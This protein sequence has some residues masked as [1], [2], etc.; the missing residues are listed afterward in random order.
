MDMAGGGMCSRLMNMLGFK[1]Y[2]EMTQNRSMVADEAHFEYRFN[3]SVGLLTGYF[4]P[5]FPV[6]TTEQDY[7]QL[8]QE[9]A[10]RIA[11][12][13]HS[14]LAGVGGTLY[15]HTRFHGALI[16][17]SEDFYRGNKS[18]SWFPLVDLKHFDLA[19]GS[20]FKY[21][22]ET[23]LKTKDTRFE[24]VVANLEFYKSLTE[25]ACRSLQFNQN[26]FLKMQQIKYEA[27][28]PEFSQSG[29]LSV[30][31]HARRGDKVS[32]GETRLFQGDE[33]VQKLTDVVSAAE[34]VIKHCFITS[35]DFRAVKEIEV[36]LR[37]RNITCSIHTLTKS[38][39]HGT[40]P[41]AKKFGHE[42]VIR[43]LTQMSI[44]IDASI[45]IGQFNSNIASLITL[46]R[47]CDSHRNSTHF[48]N[49]YGVGN[50]DWWYFI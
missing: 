14:L 1:V 40:P 46:L 22:G 10:D 3:D 48:F 33:Y 13:N 41:G 26:T 35:D 43:F 21:Y 38:N 17:D 29:Y 25:Q 7:V 30:A 45:F 32:E 44:M 47:G 11:L 42:E 2:M 49:S 27:G 23:P 9:F 12:A 39:E 15:N 28:I 37:N 24:S 18:V 36:A 20:L 19:R 31:F 6:I 34:T 5:D 16:P 4:E 50:I 8:E